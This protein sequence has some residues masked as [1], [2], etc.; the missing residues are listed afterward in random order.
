MPTHLVM[1]WN[2]NSTAK[3]LVIPTKCPVDA[4]TGDAVCLE[5]NIHRWGLILPEHLEDACKRANIKPEELKGMVLILNTG[6]HRK[7]DDS[8]EYYHYSCGYRR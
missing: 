5:I 8:K 3:G 4:Y 1:S 6:M 2:A 7:F